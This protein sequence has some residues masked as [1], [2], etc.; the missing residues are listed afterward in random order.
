MMEW[1]LAG[2]LRLLVMM[3]VVMMTPMLSIFLIYLL[4]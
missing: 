1:L 4:S 3:L 2:V